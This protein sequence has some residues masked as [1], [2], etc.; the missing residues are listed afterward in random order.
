MENQKLHPIQE[1]L[2]RLAQ[3]RSIS[4]LSLRE[5]GELVGDRSA[6][7]IKHHL[8][9]LEK[10][11]LLKIDRVNGTIEKA[12]DGWIDG[13]LQN[14]R[15]LLQIPIVGVANC[16]PAEVLANENVVGYLRVSNSIVKRQSNTGLFAVRADGF[17]MNQARVNDKTINDGDYLIID[18]S[19]CTP[20]E[21]EVILS[22]IDGSA[23]I[24]RFH[25]DKEN[26][27]V[28]LSSDSTQD[29]API[30]IHPDDDF[31]V[32]GKV[33]DVIKRPSL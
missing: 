10:R 27:Q 2:L 28:V 25:K 3:N 14:G 12:K 15:R 24:K 32:N 17:S 20:N 5:I 16:G 26:N 31:F 11:G 33:V 4:S 21:G 6:Q 23:N 30:Y 29:F 22:V 19:D 13:F 8:G 18:N 7:K 9:Q 1:K